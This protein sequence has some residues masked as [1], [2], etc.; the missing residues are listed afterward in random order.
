METI[1]IITETSTKVLEVKAIYSLMSFFFKDRV[2][3]LKGPIV[4]DGI[5]LPTGTDVNFGN[6]T[7]EMSNQKVT[8]VVTLFVDQSGI[9]LIKCF[10]KACDSLAPL[11]MPLASDGLI[12]TDVSGGIDEFFSYDIHIH[13]DP[14]H[15]DKAFF[16]VKIKAFFF[17]IIDVCLDAARP[18]FST[19]A[20]YGISKIYV[21]VG[22]DFNGGRVYFDGEVKNIFF[23]KKFSL[24]LYSWKNYKVDL[25]PVKDTANLFSA[26]NCS[27]GWVAIENEGAFVAK[28]DVS[29]T[30]NG[31]RIT[32]ESGYFT[33]GVTKVID[34][35]A[36][37]TDIVLRAWEEWFI[38]SWR[39]IFSA[40]F[41]GPVCKKYKIYGMNLNPKYEELSV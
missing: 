24:D 40:H 8:G 17:T 21:T 26:A 10:A 12:D 7:I 27:S 19:G 25:I 36:G 1:K 22:V 41:D 35:P 37:A 9:A 33:T 20:D 34:I 18:E 30:I 11:N 31:Q 28:F 13:I 38:K 3:G 23:D 2:W 4:L 16:A 32:E 39:E 5:E 14:N 29:Y 15:L 6:A